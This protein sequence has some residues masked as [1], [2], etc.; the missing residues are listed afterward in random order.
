[1]SRQPSHPA[2]SCHLMCI[3]GILEVF[4]FI[5]KQVALLISRNTADIIIIFLIIISYLP[6]LNGSPSIGFS[7]VFCSLWFFNIT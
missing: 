7:S 5:I 6:V 1:M 3:S 2:L 4:H